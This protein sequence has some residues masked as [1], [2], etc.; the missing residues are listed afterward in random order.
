V[1]VVPGQNASQIASIG[2]LLELSPCWLLRP[3]NARVHASHQSLIRNFL[4]RFL[5][6]SIPTLSC[7]LFA[8]AA[9]TDRIPALGA[10]NL[11][12]SRTLATQR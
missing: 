3:N 2:P 8:P 4:R 5:A 11:L 7:R 9:Q 6:R 12:Q 1:L 10:F